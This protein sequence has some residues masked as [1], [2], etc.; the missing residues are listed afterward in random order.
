M[1]DFL[2]FYKI[3]NRIFRLKGNII[4]IKFSVEEKS[5]QAYVP[6]D[7]LWGSIKD[8]LLNRIYEYIP[9][10]QINNLKGFTVIDAGAHVGLYSLIV[11]N[12]AEKVLS[13]EPH[14]INYRLLKINKAVNHKK[15]IETINAAIVGEKYDV[16]T[17]F[18]NEHSGGS[19]IFPKKPMKFYE[20]NSI[21][22]GQIV[23]NCIDSD[24]VLL[25]MDIEGAEFG[26]FETIDKRT[27]RNI[28]LMVME[29][30]LNYG[31]M[32]KL[33]NTLKSAKFKV[34]YFYPPLLTKN[35]KTRI[36]VK[37]LTFLKILRLIS[38]SM[39]QLLDVRDRRLVILYAWR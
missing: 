3:M 26:V 6:V 9:N 19:S 31:S 8:I 32:L 22:L 24:K 20:V 7:E 36:K 17:L 18:E 15:N 12:Y 34:I 27:L 35:V 10:F 29:L 21:T 5:L 25:K 28:Q 4:K 16:I 38:H 30:H 2:E 11:A 13:I 1:L 37:D 39:T 14:P 23:D 33:I